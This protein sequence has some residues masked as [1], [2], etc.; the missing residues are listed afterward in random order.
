M[1]LGF[2]FAP[3][4]SAQVKVIV[5]APEFDANEK[6]FAKVQNDGPEPVTFCV[7]IGQTSTQ[8][9]TTEVTPIPFVVQQ[10]TK[11]SWHTLL[12][13]PDI[14]S[15]HKAE[16]LDAGKSLEFPFRLNAAGNVRLLLS[17]WR[18]SFPQLDCSKSPK[19]SRQVKSKPFILK[20]LLEP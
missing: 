14:G 6:I 13:G 2:A 15:F 19:G 12:I 9:A 5:P 10:M 8:G 11:G 18:G 20:L 4:A 7:E 17:Y 3:A 1:V 16:V